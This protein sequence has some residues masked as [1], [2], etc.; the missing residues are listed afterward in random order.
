[1]SISATEVEDEADNSAS[2][3]LSLSNRS[4]EG[5]GGTVVFGLAADES[6]Q[7]SDDPASHVA[8]VQISLAPIQT[9][10]HEVPIEDAE[11]TYDIPES[12]EGIQGTGE[13]EQSHAYPSRFI[14][15]HVFW[16]E[17]DMRKLLSHPNRI[18]LSTG[19]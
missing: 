1:M 18:L 2:N 9:G 13:Q 17:Y 16:G 6:V 19:L 7:S 3:S 14:R 15:A 10:N 8:P 12:T 4:A 5:G 11:R